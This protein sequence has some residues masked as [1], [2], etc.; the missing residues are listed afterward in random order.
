MMLC[1]TELLQGNV[2]MKLCTKAT[3]S[4]QWFCLFFYQMTKIV[5]LPLDE[6][7]PPLTGA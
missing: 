3:V 7:L 4:R 5:L 2:S 6:G 1:K